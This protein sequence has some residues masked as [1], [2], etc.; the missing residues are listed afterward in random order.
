MLEALGEEIDFTLLLPAH[1]SLRITP[2]E[3]LWILPVR[4]DESGDAR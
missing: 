1:P 2:P 3:Q 4:P